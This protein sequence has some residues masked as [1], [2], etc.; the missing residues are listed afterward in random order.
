MD[1]S[2][3]DPSNPQNTELARLGAGRIRDLTLAT[4]TSFGF[5]HDLAG[6]HR[7]PAGE[8]SE[9]PAPG[10]AGRI[11]FVTE[12]GLER[13]ERDDGVDW[14]VFRP[15]PTYHSGST[16]PVALTSSF[17]NILSCGTNVSKN[18]K[19]II[20]FTATID[21]ASTSNSTVRT[22]VDGVVFGFEWRFQGSDA[23][24]EAVLIHTTVITTELAAGGHVVDVEVKGGL[25]SCSIAE[26][27]IIARVV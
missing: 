23:A 21:Y 10:N 1:L 20:D 4:Q 5:E 6:T 8:F 27:Q 15:N 22:K 25:G 11:Y 14:T 2:D 16:T 19:L 18:G 17:Q 24:P 26:R 12:I 7:F 9:R 3:L 13:V